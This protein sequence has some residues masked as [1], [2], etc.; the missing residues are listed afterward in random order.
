M[1]TKS[2]VLIVDDDIVALEL[3]AERLRPEGYDIVTAKGGAEAL[4]KAHKLTPDLV[5]LDVMMPEMDGFEVC[6]RLRAHPLLGE[7]PILM[8]T[9]LDDHESRLTGLEAGADDFISKSH[10]PTELKA[11]VRT[12]TRLNRYRQLLDERAKF[13]WVVRQADEGYMV[14]DDEDRILYA[15]PKARQL[16]ALDSDENTPI[17]DPFLRLATS[18][19]RCEPQRLWADWPKVPAGP[20]FLLRPESASAGVF[21]L[22]VDLLDL[23]SDSTAQLVRLRDQT[24][25]MNLGR[26]LWKFSS[27]VSEKLRTPLQMTLGSLEMI[28]QDHERFSSEEL[29]RLAG[30]AQRSGE[31]LEAQVHDILALLDNPDKA[32]WESGLDVSQ[33]KPLA[34]E[35]ADQMRLRPLEYYVREDLS[36]RLPLSAVAF[37]LILREVFDNACQFHPTSSPVLRLTMGLPDA[38]TRKVEIRIANDDSTVPAEQLERFWIPYYQTDEDASVDADTLGFGLSMVGTLVWGAG[39]TCRLVDRDDGG[40]VIEIGL[41]LLTTATS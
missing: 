8:L 14:L 25:R 23:P 32:H 7:V 41:P 1:K 20:L 17:K 37:E 36:G 11:R 26:N 30:L 24:F 18:Q 19:F 35:L 16:L 28:G 9:A 5:I 13:E 31:R 34:T 22:R 21:W 12:I 4:E 38:V 29:I 39:G 15:N 10:D 2:T 40:I 33:I 3:L 27:L 6:R